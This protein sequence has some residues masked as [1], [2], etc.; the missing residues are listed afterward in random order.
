MQKTP[1]KKGH[2]GILY[3]LPE[4]RT[5][6]GVRVLGLWKKMSLERERRMDYREVLTSLAKSLAFTPS[7]LF[8]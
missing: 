4:T 8:A 6:E 2:D 5:A 1:L 3:D 7:E